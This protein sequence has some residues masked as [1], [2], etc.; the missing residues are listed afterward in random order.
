ME[1]KAGAQISQ[2]AF[3]QSRVDRGPCLANGSS[4][5]AAKGLWASQ[6]YFAEHSARLSFE[7]HL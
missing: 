2:R 7:N 5:G 4:P 3:I 6:V 1:Q